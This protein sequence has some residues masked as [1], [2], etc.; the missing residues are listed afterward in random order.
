MFGGGG[1]GGNQRIEDTGIR[2]YTI[3]RDTE[4]SGYG[5]YQGIQRYQDMGDIEGNKDI[6]YKE[7]QYIEYKNIKI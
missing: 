4:I 1:K 2:G 3:S 5:G 6:R 7:S